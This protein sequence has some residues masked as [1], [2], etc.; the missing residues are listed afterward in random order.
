MEENILNRARGALHEAE[1]VG[2]VMEQKKQVEDRVKKEREQDEQD[3]IKEIGDDDDLELDDD[4][5]K[6]VDDML[7]SFAPK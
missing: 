2:R 1:Y 3:R 7:K 5:T 6:A 4:D